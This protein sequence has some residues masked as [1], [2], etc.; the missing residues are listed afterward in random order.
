ME[1]SI[2]ELTAA[3]K[4]AQPLLSDEQARTRALG[5]AALL[6]LDSL[7][8]DQINEISEVI[9]CALEVIKAGNPG[10]EVAQ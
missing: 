1:F 4:R 10:G 8:D 2:P 3:A 6:V 9:S 5:A 7:T